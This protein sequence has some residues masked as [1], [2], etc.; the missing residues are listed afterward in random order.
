MKKQNS[1]SDFASERSE[2]L[3]ARFRQQLA[4]Q[5]QIS[6]VKAFHEATLQEAP[7]F[8][9]SEQR[10]ATVISRMLKGETDLSDMYEE[11]REMYLEIYRRVKKLRE[12][13]PGAHVGDLVFEVINQTA[14]RS[15]MS[16]QR[17]KTL[18]NAERKRRRKER[19]SL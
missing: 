1:T 14:P 3:I 8:W 13:R 10:A 2:W 11:K 18:I 12:E 7:R 6:L 17:A 16:W 9:V 19:G 15:Y 4:R 5:S